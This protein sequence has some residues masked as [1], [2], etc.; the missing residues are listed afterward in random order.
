MEYLNKPVFRI[1]NEIDA[2]NNWTRLNKIERDCGNHGKE[3][4][5]QKKEGKRE[6]QN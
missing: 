3:D 2:E 6:R 1:K 5:K 4:K